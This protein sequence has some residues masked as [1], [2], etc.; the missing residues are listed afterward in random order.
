[1]RYHGLRD[2]VCLRFVD[3][4]DQTKGREEVPGPVTDLSNYAFS[5]LRAGDLALYRGCGEGLPPILLAAAEDSSLPCLKRL[6]HEYALR[7]NLDA[8]SDVPPSGHSR[9]RS[10][11]GGA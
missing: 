1:M 6:E 3:Y 9:D 10:A 11:P 2:V 7:A 4:R 8:A 5:R